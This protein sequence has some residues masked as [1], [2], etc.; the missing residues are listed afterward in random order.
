MKL[1]LAAPTQENT[2]SAYGDRHVTVN[3]QRYP[4]SVVVTG[5]QLIVDWKG[6]TFDQLNPER[7]EV[8]LVLNAEIILLGTGRKLRFPN[9]ALLRPLIQARVGIEV[10]DNGA[11]CRTY[12]I[13]LAEGRNVAAVILID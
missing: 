5:Q 13:L 2:F 1:H 11:A 6:V 7:L 4:H 9:P 12:N 3:G 10:M 8:L